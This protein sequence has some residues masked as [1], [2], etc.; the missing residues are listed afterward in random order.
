[1]MNIVSLRKTNPKKQQSLRRPAIMITLTESTASPIKELRNIIRLHMNQ[2]T[3]ISKFK[4][5]HL[6]NSTLPSITMVAI[7]NMRH[8]TTRISTQL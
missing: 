7:T 2:F 4:N 3:S 1:M 8:P 6:S 5:Q